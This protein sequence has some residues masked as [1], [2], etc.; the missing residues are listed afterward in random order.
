MY[1]PSK[2]RGQQFASPAEWYALETFLQVLA[3]SRPRGE[4]H[5]GPG[6][7]Q[8]CQRIKEVLLGSLSHSLTLIFDT[9]VHK[10]WSDA[11]T[12]RGSASVD[13]IEVH[14][15]FWLQALQYILFTLTNTQ[16]ATSHSYVFLP[17]YTSFFFLSGPTKQGAT[18]RNG[19]ELHV[20][21][22]HVTQSVTHTHLTSLCCTAWW[23]KCS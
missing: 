22:P 7:Q 18:S 14:K 11:H 3:Q 2:A 4:W 10:V 6:I 15:P 1:S 8:K 17:A 12:E 16:K 13:R 19:M 23:C 20:V 5:A 21:C 9:Y